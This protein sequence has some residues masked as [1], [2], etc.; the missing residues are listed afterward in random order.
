MCSDRS[1]GRGGA[2]ISPQGVTSFGFLNAP[3]DSRPE[4]YGGMN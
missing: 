4:F 1:A 2:E 3:V